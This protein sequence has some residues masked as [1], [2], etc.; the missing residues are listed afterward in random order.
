LNSQIIEDFALNPGLC[1]L[2]LIMMWMSMIVGDV[3]AILGDW[4][5]FGGSRGFIKVSGQSED[6]ADDSHV[7]VIVTKIPDKSQS[8]GFIPIHHYRRWNGYLICDPRCAVTAETL[9]PQR[10]HH[11]WP[12]LPSS[13]SRSSSSSVDTF[14]SSSV[15]NS[16]AADTDKSLG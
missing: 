9:R 13:D 1:P 12:H 3:T 5:I 7:Y 11:P 15:P 6:A 16:F 4:G 8:T 2:N 10:P 14:A